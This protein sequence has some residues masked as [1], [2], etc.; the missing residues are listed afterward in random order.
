M[1]SRVAL[2]DTWNVTV[3]GNAAYERVTDL[4]PL[5]QAAVAAASGQDFNHSCAPEQGRLLSVLARGYVGSRIGETGTGCGVGLAWMVDATDA[6]TSILSA[7]ID[8]ALAETAAKLF[9]GHPNV[10]VIHSDWTELLAFGP[11]DLLVLDGG[12]K[13]KEPAEDPPL[14]PTAGWLEVGGTIVLDDFAPGDSAHDD[15]RRYWI[16]HPALE[17]TELVL[18]PS[19][20]TLVGR[21]I[22]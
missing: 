17:V 10:R 3:G 1:S 8:A 20:S 7:E 12:G 18:T 16:N 9:T 15:A 19:L 2:T 14:D 11:F 4:P 6:S 13:G 5:V 22:R 21:R